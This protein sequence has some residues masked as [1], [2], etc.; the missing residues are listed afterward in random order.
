[1]ICKITA[2][3]RIVSLV[4]VNLLVLRYRL[5]VCRCAICR[6]A[7]RYWS[8][9]VVFC[10]AESMG[11]LY[12]DLDLD[13]DLYLDLSLL[14][15]RETFCVDSSFNGRGRLHC[16]L[17]ILAS[18]NVLSVELLSLLCIRNVAACCWGGSLGRFEAGQLLRCTVCVRE[19]LL[20]LVRPDQSGRSRWRRHS[21]TDSVQ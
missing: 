3:H 5:V 17:F 10:C 9:G 1:M 4:S 2:E 18:V 8:C 15:F 16:C 6:T 7:A 19:C 12:L 11:N 21:N 20:Y 14:S 13:L